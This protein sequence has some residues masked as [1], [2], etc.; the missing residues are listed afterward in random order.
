MFLC[1]A[2]SQPWM[3]TGKLA[4]G[5]ARGTP[6]QTTGSADAGSM[7]VG[8]GRR[9]RSCTFADRDHSAGPGKGLAENN[10]GGRTRRSPPPGF[11]DKRQESLKSFLEEE[12][13]PQD[14]H[15][16]V[17][18]EALGLELA[19]E[20]ARSN[21][22]S[23][24]IGTVPGNLVQ[25]GVARLVHERTDLA[26]VDVEDRQLDRTRLRQRETEDRTRVERV[27]RV[28]I[29]TRDPRLG[30]LRIPDLSHVARLL[31]ER[32]DVGRTAVDPLETSGE[33]VH[34]RVDD[35]R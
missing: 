28:L 3:P 6:F 30:D 17:G 2:P 26:T 13:L 12:R 15:L 11:T 33:L 19:P 16:L 31:A 29:E 23:G 27:R 24:V 7:F 4:P 20:H 35:V 1:I 10:L 18:R 5:R 32:R 14:H 21:R 8:E 25:T 34:D 9:S 22:T